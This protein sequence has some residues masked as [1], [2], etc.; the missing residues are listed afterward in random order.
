MESRF[1][2]QTEADLNAWNNLKREEAVGKLTSD[3]RKASRL[4]HAISPIEVEE[5]RLIVR[6]PKTLPVNVINSLAGHSARKSPDRPSKGNG[7]RTPRR[8]KLV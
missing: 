3:K 6:S 2:V 1:D 4:S 8:A 7:D 5:L